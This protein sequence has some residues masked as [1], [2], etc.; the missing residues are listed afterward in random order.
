MDIVNVN[1]IPKEEIWSFYFGEDF[2]P[3]MFGDSESLNFSNSTYS[4]QQKAKENF[5]ANDSYILVQLCFI[6]TLLAVLGIL[7]GF[8]ALT[9][10]LTL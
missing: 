9:V 6:L 1:L 4:E 2:D 8:V 5:F 3:G 7:M 10:K